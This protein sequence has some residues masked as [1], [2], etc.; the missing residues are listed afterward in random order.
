[1]NPRGAGDFRGFGE[2]GSPPE[3]RL[4]LA[5]GR[6]SDSTDQKESAQRFLALRLHFPPLNNATDF[7][8]NEVVASSVFKTLQSMASSAATWHDNN[9]L[10]Q[11]KNE[12]LVDLTP[13]HSC[14]H[15]HR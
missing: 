14:L 12:R 9:R 15:K 4:A 6:L 2:H 11:F 3:I 8:A 5:S 10:N 7:R 1:L 13:I